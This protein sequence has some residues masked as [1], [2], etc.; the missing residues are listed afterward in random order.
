[1]ATATPTGPV[2]S[3]VQVSRIPGKSG[4]NSMINSKRPRLRLSPDAYSLLH[5]SVLERDSWRCQICGSMVGLE[6]HHMIPKSLL[7]PDAEE[8]LITLRP[9]CHDKIHHL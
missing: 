9:R 4:Y 1:M 5:R 2:R 8:N 3:T 7:G 6:V